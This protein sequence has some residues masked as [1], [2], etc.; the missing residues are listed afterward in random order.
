M[1]R[2]HKEELIVRLVRGVFEDK[3]LI[4]VPCRCLTCKSD[5][6]REVLLESRRRARRDGNAAEVKRISTTI[7]T[8]PLPPCLCAHVLFLD[9][10]WQLQFVA[11]FRQHMSQNSRTAANMLNG[12]RGMQ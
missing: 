7:R 4:L 8:P 12:W 11:F 1:E 2:Q 6:A 5:P 9:V 10:G 3:A